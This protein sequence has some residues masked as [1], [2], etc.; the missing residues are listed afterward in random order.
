M[1]SSRRAYDDVVTGTA[2]AVYGDLDLFFAATHP[3]EGLRDLLVTALGPLTGIRPDAPP[4]IR[5]E[6]NLGGGKTTI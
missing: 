4:V 3:S 5:L 1:Q 6:T 2:P